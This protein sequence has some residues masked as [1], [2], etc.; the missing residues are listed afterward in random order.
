MDRITA[1]VVFIS[2]VD[3]G[4]MAAAA[5]TLDMSPSMVTRYLAQM[6]E[7]AGSRLLHRSTRSLSLTNSGEKVIDYC[8]KL[9]LLADDIS[10][11]EADIDNIPH[12]LLRI[13]SS[14][15]MAQ[16]L[17]PFIADFL[18]RYPQVAI[19]LHISNYAVNLVKE[20][21]DLAIR[22]TN[23]LDPNIFAQPMGEITSVLCASPDYFETHNKPHQISQ[24]S[25]HNCLT[26]SYFGKSIWEF[27][28]DGEVFSVDVSGN[29]SANESV[30]LLKAT[31]YGTGISLQPKS[32]V[33][34]YL[35]N[36]KLVELLP[37]YRVKKLGI[38]G[39]YRSRKHK[40]LAFS[41]FIN[42]LKIF[43]TQSDM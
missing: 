16:V 22:I 17:G 36:G 43:F 11:S 24:L 20:R 42:E 39:I 7:W 31:I 37:D 29:F 10:V 14:Q 5:R 26:Y 4:S 13:S 30:V 9:V 3:Q 19:N 41:L 1:S 21:I 23:D 2:I 33:I 38:Y 40:S 6:E 34:P 28:N 27:S 8:R 25:K 18:H 12:G 15:F 35:N 32:D